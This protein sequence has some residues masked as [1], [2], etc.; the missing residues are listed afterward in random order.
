MRLVACPEIP[1]E[2]KGKI[3][4][5]MATKCPFCNKSLA[6]HKTHELNIPTKKEAA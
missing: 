6:R 5:V 4:A 1:A 3:I 2:D